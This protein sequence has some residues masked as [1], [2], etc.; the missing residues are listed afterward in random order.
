MQQ[1]KDVCAYFQ[2]YEIVS[3]VKVSV[4]GLFCISKVLYPLVWFVFVR[5]QIDENK[6]K[7]NRI[8]KYIKS[9]MALSSS[10]RLSFLEGKN[11]LIF[12]TETTGLPDRVPGAKWGTAGEYWPYN[13]NEKYA[14]ARIVSIAWAFV[15]SYNRDTLSVESINEHIRYPEGFSEIPTTEIH[16]I[17]FEHAQLKGVPMLDII[18]NCSLADAILECDYIIAH[19][20]MFDVHILQNELFRLGDDLS[21]ECAMKLDKMKAQGRTICTGELGKDICQL[22]FKSRSGRDT[23]RVK[24][25]KMPKLKELHYHLMGS[26]HDNQHAAGGDVLALLNCLSKM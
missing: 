10:S 12:D 11:V 21:M 4:S 17:S 6:Y 19:N 25:F 2:A 8:V 22:E 15:R 3:K 9:N 24:R 5:L 18:E 23:S 16:G 7:S 26:E 20:I 13:M 14:N 1:T